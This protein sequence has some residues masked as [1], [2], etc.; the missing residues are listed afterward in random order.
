MQTD[1]II[2]DMDGTLWDTCQVVA[3]SWTRAVKD[4]GIDK[5]FSV[6]LIRSCMGMMMEAF[7]AKCMPEIDEETR[8]Q[9][10]KKCFEYENGYLAKHGGV[11][12]EDVMETL[13]ALWEKYPLFIVS[14]CQD[15]YIEAFFEG[16]HTGT[17]FAD[18][19][20]P[21]RTGLE[22]AKNI[23]LIC[24]RNHLENP[25]YVGD[26]EGDLEACRKAGVPFIYAAYGFGEVPEGYA[27]K[28]EAFSELKNLFL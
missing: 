15:G 28:L 19:E 6:E 11:L 4:C 23:R 5:N 2:F 24:E 7:V 3:D 1:G 27:A 20:N 10:A 8:M 26:T 17:L 9:C 13:K 14:N 25:V 16:H 18:Y 21:G 12:F 22:K